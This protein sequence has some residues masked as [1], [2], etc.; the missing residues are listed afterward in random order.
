MACSAQTHVK[1]HE[2]SGFLTAYYTTKLQSSKQYGTAQ[3]QNYRSMEQENPEMSP[4]TYGE[5][6]YD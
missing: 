5:P 1:M 4:C 6:I 2:E 3:K